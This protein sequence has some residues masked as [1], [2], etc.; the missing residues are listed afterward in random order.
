MTSANA[1]IVTF[2]FEG[3]VTNVDE[4]VRRDNEAGTDTGAPRDPKAF[5]P[6]D[7]FSGTYTY[8]SNSIVNRN[9]N[10][11]TFHFYDYKGVA[12]AM[13]LF[14]D[15][16]VMAKATNGNVFYSVE[17]ASLTD[18]VYYKAE[19]PA[20]AGS[21]G[22]ITYT[23]L[24]LIDEIYNPSKIN[25]SWIMPPSAKG[26]S[27]YAQIDPSLIGQPHFDSTQK[28]LDESSF[29][30]PAPNYGDFSLTYSQRSGSKKPAMSGRL[31]SVKRIYPRWNI[32]VIINNH[33]PVINN[34]GFILN[35]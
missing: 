12:S 25:L 27:D 23:N 3:M 24:N 14:H 15:T 33:I 5:S 10:S 20:S 28:W 4:E 8:D 6:G 9:Q 32:P 26:T 35:P 19:F 34:N 2:K 13:S 30:L 7:K 1:E 31:Y 21:Q 11:T 29:W 16:N 17:G 18:S 22:T